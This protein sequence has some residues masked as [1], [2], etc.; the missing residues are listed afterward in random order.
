MSK[1]IVNNK[2][3]FYLDQG[4]GFPLLFGHS[5]LW[6]GTMWQ[7]QIERF[8]AAYRCLSTDLWGHGRSALLNSSSYSLEQLAD[9]MWSFLQALAI[10]RFILIGSSVG[11]MWAV[12]LALKYPE[13]VAGLVLIGTYVGAEPE[14][15]RKR[16]LEMIAIGEKAQ[17]MPNPLIEQIIP[18]F[19]APSTVNH[20]PQLIE[21]FRERLSQLKGERLADVLTIGKAIFNRK[22]VLDQLPNIKCPVLVVVGKEDLSR[23]PSESEEMVAKLE[24]AKLEIIP[25]A[26]HITNLEQPEQVNDL[27]QNFLEIIQI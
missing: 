22:S 20:R 15:S 7:P 16:Y 21:Q 13:A 5:F 18:L 23:P 12:N 6:D 1:V 19:F 10:D 24:N 11:G 14:A 17:M 27:L 8:S 2:E 25:N 9:E 26:G 3:L 4:K